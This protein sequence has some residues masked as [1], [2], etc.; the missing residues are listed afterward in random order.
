[1]SILDFG[2]VHAW[3]DVNSVQEIYAIDGGTAVVSLFGPLST[4]A[5]GAAGPSPATNVYLNPPDNAAN[6]PNSASL[7]LRTTGNGTFP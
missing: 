5:G 7:F 3:D 2:E 6:N 4:T 1:M